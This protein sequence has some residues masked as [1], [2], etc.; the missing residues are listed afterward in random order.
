MGL[1]HVLNHNEQERKITYF[2]ENTQN[3]QGL[4]FLHAGARVTPKGEADGHA[5]S[6]PALVATWAVFSLQRLWGKKM[7][8]MTE[9]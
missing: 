2:L 7:L 3:S 1:I 6:H 9:C 5:H 8:E 4:A